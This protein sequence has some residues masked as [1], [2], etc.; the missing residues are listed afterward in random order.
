MFGSNIF[1]SWFYINS[2]E[3]IDVGCLDHLHLS[4]DCLVLVRELVPMIIRFRGW[5]VGFVWIVP[6]RDD[7]PVF[8]LV[9]ESV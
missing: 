8:I 3:V 2:I 4:Q 6:V 7:L 1:C 9:K 5:G